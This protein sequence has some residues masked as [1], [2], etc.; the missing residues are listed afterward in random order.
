MSIPA[1]I[2]MITYEDGPAALAWLAEAFGFEVRTELYDEAGRLSHAELDTG[3]GLV[4]IASPTPAYVGPRR[5]RELCTQAASW[6]A[7]PW[8]ID[9]TLVVVTDVA[10]HHARA[11]AAGAIVL[12]PPEVAGPGHLYRAEDP[13]GHRWMFLQPDIFTDLATNRG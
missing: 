5:M 11:V 13:Q 12:S 3:L 7:L 1:V 2:P 4:M 10:A 9:G 8:V 6:S